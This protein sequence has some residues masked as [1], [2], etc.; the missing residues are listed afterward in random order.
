MIDFKTGLIDDAFLYYKKAFP[1]QVLVSIV[2]ILLL[3]FPF[4]VI[5]NTLL[6]LHLN[7]GSETGFYLQDILLILFAFLVFSAIHI[8]FVK[9]KY[10]L[11][12][13][14]DRN[15]HVN[16]EK[17]SSEFAD[18]INNSFH[19]QAD[20]KKLIN[21]HI[22]DIVS[23]TD[24]AAFDIM[25]YAKSIDGSSEFLSK[26]VRDIR[27][28]FEVFSSKAHESINDN[29]ETIEMLKN[30]IER[31]ELDIK[32]D[33]EIAKMIQGDAG[34]L[35]SF[36]SL[37]EDIAQ[38]I[39]LLALNASIEAARAGEFGRGF[40][41]VAEEVRKLSVK[42][43]TAATEVKKA[44]K[45]MKG[46]VDAQLSDKAD[47]EKINRE[48]EFLS[49]LEERLGLVAES[50]ISM[51]KMSDKII[52][53][54]SD[55]VREVGEKVISLLSNIQ[56]Q[57]ITRQQMEKI[58]EINKQITDILLFEENKPDNF[59]KKVEMLNSFDIDK[60]KDIYI[61]EEQRITHDNVKDKSPEKRKEEDN[62]IVFF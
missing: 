19:K 35:S 23:K 39:N 20:I 10:G 4:T 40:S 15:S 37:M 30:F 5:F 7:T 34:Q 50:Y 36:I 38:Q 26:E 3:L 59:E 46:N 18:K 2:L 62:N 9:K 21:A 58:K 12:S 53:R 28:D 57:D 48:N 61:M 43:N 1:I 33:L 14:A 6:S 11:V 16:A 47:A 32:K 29:R 17:Q 54:V 27:K 22:D 55:G 56:F 13:E 44:V 45:L 25:D 8:Y 41:V 52:N 49:D 31:R 60:F 42:S 24:K 51:N